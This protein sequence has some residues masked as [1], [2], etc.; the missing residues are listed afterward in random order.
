MVNKFDQEQVGSS[1]STSQMTSLGRS[2]ILCFPH[3]VFGNDLVRSPDHCAYFPKAPREKLGFTLL[4][5]RR[6]VGVTAQPGLALSLK[7][8]HMRAKMD[9]NSLAFSVLRL[10]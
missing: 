2:A 9:K 8:Y 7:R 5:G 3:P 1:I 10:G 6:Q 4:L